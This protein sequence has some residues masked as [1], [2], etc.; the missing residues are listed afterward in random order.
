MQEVLCGECGKMINSRDD[1]YTFLSMN[2]IQALCS[3]CYLRSQKRIRGVRTPINS[4]STIL[5]MIAGIVACLLLFI[6]HPSWIWVV[7][8]LIAPVI[9]SLSWFLF[10]RKLNA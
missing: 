1:L 10:E 5:I 6:W 7:V 4:Q 9:R 2:G 3:E 8:A